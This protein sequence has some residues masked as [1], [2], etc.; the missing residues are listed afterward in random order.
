[1]Q[2]K[3]KKLTADLGAITTTLVQITNSVNEDNLPTDV[4][5]LQKE[6]KKT[7][8]EKRLAYEAEAVSKEEMKKVLIVVEATIEKAKRQ[9]EIARKAL[10]KARKQNELARK[11]AN[12]ANEANKA[13]RK[14][15]ENCQ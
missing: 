10:E 1:L 12:K 9:S 7:K 15:L 13:L 11:E 14:K 4:L 5:T 3:V 8:E 2:E 6:L